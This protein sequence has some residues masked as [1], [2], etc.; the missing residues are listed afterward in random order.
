MGLFDSILG[1]MNQQTQTSGGANPLI[2]IIGGL[3]QQSGGLQG[4]M[5]KFNQAGQGNAFAS[6]VGTGENQQVSGSQIENVLGSEQVQALAA[7]LGI[8][9]NQASHFLAQ[10]LPQVV[11]QM[12]PAGKIDPAT[13]HQQSLADLIPGLM[14]SLGTDRVS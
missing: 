11:D 5:A 12:T 4:L 3:L 2:G 7:K 10:Y 6:W 8:D 14:Q 1:A 9:P 13:D